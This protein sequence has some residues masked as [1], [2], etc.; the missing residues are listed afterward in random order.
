MG[1]SLAANTE[2]IKDSLAA[3]ASFSVATG[4]DD[5]LN[6]AEITAGSDFSGS[7]NNIIPDDSQYSMSFTVDLVITDG[8]GETVEASTE[9]NADGSWSIAGLDLASLA[10]GAITANVST[11][12]QAG[13]SATRYL[14]L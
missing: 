6:L 8:L 4:S 12:D 11:T 9:L 13:N 5:T 2:T 1:G 7:F 14:E 10:D 3:S